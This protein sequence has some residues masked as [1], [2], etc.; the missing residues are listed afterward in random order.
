MESFSFPVSAWGDLLPLLPRH[1]PALE[2]QDLVCSCFAKIAVLRRWVPN[3]QTVVSHVLSSFPAVSPGRER[4][5]LVTPSERKS[6][7]SWSFRVSF[8]CLL[9]APSN[10]TPCYD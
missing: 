5:V 8:P 6:G 7:L 9:S 4:P 1:R 2:S 10:F 3:L